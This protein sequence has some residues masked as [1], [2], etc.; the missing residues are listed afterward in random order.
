MAYQQTASATLTDRCY[1][2]NVSSFPVSRDQVNKTRCRIAMT[3]HGGNNQKSEFCL[4]ETSWREIER[5]NEP[6][7]GT[8]FSIKAAS[9]DRMLTKAKNI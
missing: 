2:P 7:R 8:F 5:E 6:Q 4:K 1:E 9:N 3:T